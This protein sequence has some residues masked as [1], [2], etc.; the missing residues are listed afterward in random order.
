MNNMSL[1][2]RVRSLLPA[3]QD[4]HGETFRSIVEEEPLAKFASLFDDSP[5]LSIENGEDLMLFDP[6]SSHFGIDS[7][8]GMESDTSDSVPPLSK[9]FFPRISQPHD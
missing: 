2:D 9:P 7:E 8:F 3:T 4:V 6:P 5:V 1:E